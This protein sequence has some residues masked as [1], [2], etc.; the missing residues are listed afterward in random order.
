MRVKLNRGM[1]PFIANEA[2]ETVFSTLLP[3]NKPH[4]TKLFLKAVKA[5]DSMSLNKLDSNGDSMLHVLGR[6]KINSVQ[7]TFEQLV[8]LGADPN[9]MNRSGQT[10]LHILCQRIV[11]SLAEGEIKDKEQAKND[12]PMEPEEIVLNSGFD[13]TIS[14]LKKYGAD[15]HISDS[16]DQTCIDF[17]EN[18]K[19]TKL[20]ALLE[21]PT[22]QI[23][24][25]PLLPWIQQSDKH[26]PLLGQVVRHQRSKQI[27][28]FHYNIQPIGNGAFGVVYA[29]I[30][31]K[32]GREV[33]VKSIS[34]PIQCFDS[35]GNER[36]IKNL[37]RL[38]DCEHI[39]KYYNYCKTGDSL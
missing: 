1:E 6:H 33:A 35:L 39:V 30:H 18:Y 3:V 21:K 38:K 24:I 23:V 4:Q 28:S 5:V 26:K 25:P 29:G 37:L 11:S 27:E 36:E 32:D 8:K 10:P 14:A 34:L 31:E 17:A 2:C 19:L 9:R 12:R 16:D 22:D 15:P 13:W 20:K 7:E